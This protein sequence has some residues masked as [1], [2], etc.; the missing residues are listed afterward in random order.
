MAWKK[1]KFKKL[2][3]VGSSRDIKAG[4]GIRCPHCLRD[5]DYVDSDS[6]PIIIIKY[7]TRESFCPYCY[8]MVVNE[9]VL[10]QLEFPGIEKICNYC[11]LPYESYWK[12]QHFCDPCVTR[13]SFQ[14]FPNYR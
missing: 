6:I 1:I 14:Y 2:I 12:G 9:D 10:K 7:N 13:N 5:R 3:A 8:E 11:N 4:V